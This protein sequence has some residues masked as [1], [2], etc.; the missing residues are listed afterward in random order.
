[1]IWFGLTLRR[2]A[3]AAEA[4]LMLRYA[5]DDLGCRRMQW[6]GNALNAALRA[7]ARRLGFRFEGIFYNHMIFK[8][9]SGDT[10][11]HSILDDAAGPMVNQVP[12][13][14]S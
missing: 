12:G 5:M 3:S 9:R 10:A 8:G 7:A 4:L 6:R 11:W 14:R 1:M 2:T 13:R